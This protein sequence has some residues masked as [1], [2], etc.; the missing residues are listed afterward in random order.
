MTKE[1]QIINKEHDTFTAIH[2]GENYTSPT[3]N[4]SMPV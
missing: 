2:C 1:H 4:L 3:G